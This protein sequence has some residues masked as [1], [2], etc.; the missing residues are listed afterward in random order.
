MA[1]FSGAMLVSGRVVGIVRPMDPLTGGNRGET[2]AVTLAHLG[3]AKIAKLG[4]QLVPDKFPPWERIGPASNNS[5]TNQGFT[6][7]LLGGLV[8]YFKKIYKQY[9]YF[10]ELNLESLCFEG[11]HCKHKAFSI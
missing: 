8:S 2:G 3:H 6:V 10:V 5:Y 7:F 9:I 4:S 1:I 11:Q